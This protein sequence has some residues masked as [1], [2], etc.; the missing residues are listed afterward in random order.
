F[1]L[2]GLPETSRPWQ[3]TVDGSDYKRDGT[4]PEKKS[5]R[6]RQ[7]RRNRQETHDQIEFARFNSA[8]RL[9]PGTPFK[10]DT[11]DIVKGGQNLAPVVVFKNPTKAPGIYTI[12]P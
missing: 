3:N 2:L 8:S 9:P 4:S 12:E 1:L 6:T 5:K 11:K 7:D 10:C